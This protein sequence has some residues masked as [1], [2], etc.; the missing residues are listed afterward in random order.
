MVNKSVDNNVKERKKIS[1]KTA[2]DFHNLII[3]FLKELNIKAVAID[4]G[5]NGLK[6]YSIYGRHLVPS[7]P[8]K[9]GKANRLDISTIGSNPTDILYKDENDFVWFIGDLA[10]EMIDSGKKTYNYDILYGRN[11]TTTPEYKVLLRTGMALSLI[12]NMD[13]LKKP[14]YKITSDNLKVMTGLP[15]DWMNDKDKLINVFS[16]S[17]KF[18]IKIGNSGWI[19][20]SFEL[21][22]TSEKDVFVMSQPK[23]TIFSLATSV[24]GEIIKPELLLTNNV[25]VFD[26][27]FGTNDIYYMKKGQKASSTSFTD[28]AMFEVYKATCSDIL[29]GTKNLRE[30]RVYEIDKYIESNYTV[31]Y[32]ETDDKGKL[33]KYTFDFKEAIDKNIEE[34]AGDA[35]ERMSNLYEGFQDV[36]YVICTGGTGEAYHPHFERDIPTNVILAENLD[37]KNPAENFT[38]VYSNAIGFF[39][40]LVGTLKKL[41]YKNS[42]ENEAVKEVASTSEKTE[43]VKK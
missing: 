6:V 9:M 26:G 16:G 19:P 30:V 42:R 14:N 43:K 2:F 7:L 36:D 33:N 39:C 11:R 37:S 35:F 13:N 5:Y 31:P 3:P 40:N 22:Q 18:S 4:I 12:E 27:G 15:E 38:P 28:N 21:N 20:V 10:K 8:I 32:Q 23:G 34:F 41:Y 24:Y 29:E 17:H 25:L 1:T